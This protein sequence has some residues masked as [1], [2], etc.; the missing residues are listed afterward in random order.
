MSLDLKFCSRRTTNYLSLDNITA[1]VF[2][3]RGPRDAAI[4][5][6]QAGYQTDF[7]HAVAL[8]NFDVDRF[9]VSCRLHSLQNETLSVAVIL[10]CCHGGCRLVIITDLRF[11][12]GE[13]L[14]LIEVLPGCELGVIV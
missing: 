4:L 7:S 9:I 5:F 2:R 6:V 10:G 13:K 3:Q 11:V 8:L 1:A 14:D 12:N